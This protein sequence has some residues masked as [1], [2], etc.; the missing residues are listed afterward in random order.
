MQHLLL[1]HC[2]VVLLASQLL[3]DGLKRVQFLLV[4][5]L[6]LVE[7]ELIV[8]LILVETPLELLHLILVAALHI[9]EGFDEL[10]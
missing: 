7:G 3:N 4:V 5:L 9:L 8:F 1:D 2:E 10:L 6:Q